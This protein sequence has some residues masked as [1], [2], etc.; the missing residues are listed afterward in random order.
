MQQSAR[1]RE[2]DREDR[3]CR[4]VLSLEQ[5]NEIN[6]L[7]FE[8]ESHLCDECPMTSFGSFMTIVNLWDSRVLS[9]LASQEQLV[10]TLV[11]NCSVLHFS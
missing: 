10:C 7:W 1:S 5:L 8:E 4:E 3:Q 2:R 6:G 11:N 9:K